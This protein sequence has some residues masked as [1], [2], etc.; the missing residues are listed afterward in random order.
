MT[1]RNWSPDEHDNLIDSQNLEISVR[2]RILKIMES[3]D[4]SV[5]YGDDWN[6]EDEPFVI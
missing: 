1:T 4:K 6:V 3:Y 5:N 2:N